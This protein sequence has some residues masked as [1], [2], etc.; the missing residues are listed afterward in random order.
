MPAIWAVE[1]RR[2]RGI[3]RRRQIATALLTVMGAT[4]VLGLLPPL[5]PLLVIHV[6][7]DA[8]FVG[9]LLLLARMR[10][11]VAEQQMAAHFARN[12]AEQK[13]AAEMTTAQHYAVGD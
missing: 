2:L 6:F 7:A 9:Y 1:A 3:R 8:A 4:L 13:A 12:R 10:A 5:R 11:M